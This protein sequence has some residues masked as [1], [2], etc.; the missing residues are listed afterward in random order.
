[1]MGVEKR[2]TAEPMCGGPLGWETS[3][4]YC[5]KDLFVGIVIRVNADF[6]GHKLG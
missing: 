2:H 6:T 4:R 1:M 5:L 3:T